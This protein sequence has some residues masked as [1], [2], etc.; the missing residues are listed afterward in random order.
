MLGVWGTGKLRLGEGALTAWLHP[1]GP[2]GSPV[3][4]RGP[5]LRC[6]GRTLVAAVG[7]VPQYPLY[8]HRAADD[9]VLAVSSE[10]RALLALVDA[11]I[12]EPRLVSLIVGCEDAD[13]GATVYRRLRR[14]QPCETIYADQDGIRLGRTFPRAG[15]EFLGEGPEEL[16][17]ELR[18]R[19]DASIGRAIEGSRRVTVLAGG[20]LD[21]AGVVALASARLGAEGRELRVLAHSCATPGDDRPH[22]VELERHLGFSAQR[23][24][25]RTAAPWFLHS[26]CADAQ[27]APYMGT[28]LDM[29]LLLAAREPSSVTL[30]GHAGDAVF[31]GRIDFSTFLRRGHPFRAM[32]TAVKLRVP[33]RVGA[34]KRIARWVV[35]PVL[36]PFVP[37]A[38]IRARRR[39][40]MRRPWMTERFRQ[41]LDASI[42]SNPIELPRT[43]DE[44]LA[45]YCSSSAL[46]E[47]ATT[48]GQIASVT[49]ATAVDIFCDLSIVCL[50]AQTDPAVRCHGHM[51]R[52]LYRLAL[53][54]LVPDSVRLRVDKAA[55]QP[56]LAEA[57][58]EAHALASLEDLSSLEALADLGLVVPFTFRS[59]FS[60]W[61]RAVRRGERLERDPSDECWH[62]VWQL[63][64][65]ERFV[66]QARLGW[67]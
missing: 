55:G 32:A 10:L 27:P 44:E 35:G 66:R 61:L 15:A 63:L 20:G 5:E 2:A 8:Y 30:T 48:W 17:S 18:R 62:L 58:L 7:P 64:S 42:R 1:S 40:R 52:G 59:A 56:M 12:N 24:S 67:A 60:D 37:G 4:A 65:V 51:A 21:S 9:S 39:G 14:L 26:L 16:A 43:P 25:P 41:L 11:D 3:E 28:C 38:L 36:R 54:G 46:A 47:S 45:A 53:R 29:H 23:E 19:V 6:V 33:S 57:A 31:G 34:P 13:R 50:M 22:L 49:G